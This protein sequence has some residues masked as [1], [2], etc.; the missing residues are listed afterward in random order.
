MSAAEQCI[1]INGVRLTQQAIKG[2]RY[3]QGENNSVLNLLMS[4]L[5]KVND[6][7]INSMQRGDSDNLSESLQMLI[8]LK[9]CR[10]SLNDLQAPETKS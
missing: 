6:Y 9:E 4:D 10:E 7:L 1:D 3:L 2:L 5:I 8:A